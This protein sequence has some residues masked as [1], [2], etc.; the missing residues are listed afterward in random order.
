MLSNSDDTV[1]ADSSHTVTD[2]SGSGTTIKCF[3]GNTPLL[4]DQTS[5][6][7]NGTFRVSAAVT[8]GTITIG[9]QSGAD[10]G[11]T[12]TYAQHSAMSTDK[13]QITY[14][15]TVKSSEGVETVFSP[16]QTITKSISGAEGNVGADGP[17][18]PSPVYRGV[19]SAGTAYYGNPKRVDIVQYP[20]GGSYYVT[21]SDIDTT[22]PYDTTTTGN[23]PTDTDYWNPFGATF[24]SIATGLLFANV[25]YI[26]N[27]GVR[28]FSGAEAAA[29]TLHGHV[30]THQSPV[31]GESQ[32][33]TVT[34]TSSTA[35][36]YLTIDGHTHGPTAWD[37]DAAT[38][39]YH[40][41][42]SFG[43]DFP[44]VS[45]AYTFGNDYLVITADATG[46]P[47][48]YSGVSVTT[49]LDNASVV[50]VAQIDYIQMSGVGGN[51]IIASNGAQ[52]YSYY[53]YASQTGVDLEETAKDFATNASNISTFATANI[54][55]SYSGDTV[56]LTA[57]GAQVGLAFSPATTA[58]NNPVGMEGGVSIRENQ[59]FEDKIDGDGGYMF[60]NMNGYNGGTSHYRALEIGDGKGSAVVRI[61]G[62]AA[63]P[64]ITLLN[65]P[66]VGS[67]GT[68]HNGI[69]EVDTNGFLKLV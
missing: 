56:I 39:M 11:T 52:A 24:D 31:L 41:Y 22:P 55:L 21:R 27:L 48:T 13:A 32:I 7:G 3:E 25:A 40:F 17:L 20:A 62:A 36:M 33:V 65:V 67:T 35:D 10:G 30:T 4:I 5:T 50:A 43:T 9:G 1:P 16:I 66:Q 38:T 58:G 47:F 46:T 28:Y 53:S 14:T 23:L 69:L 15:V 60:I 34:K 12:I 54:T 2:Y 59:I 64:W 63:G 8:L 19:Y 6:F 57:T 18:G 49:N 29:G 45:M 68:K 26:D 51:A 61:A 37:T 42:M 44:G